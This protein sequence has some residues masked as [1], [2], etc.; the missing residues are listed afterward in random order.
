VAEHES[1]INQLH[2]DDTR[3]GSELAAS[4]QAKDDLQAEHTDVQS[5]SQG[6]T[7]TH[8]HAHTH[9]KQTNILAQ[10]FILN[11]FRTA[12]ILMACYKG[13]TLVRINAQ[14]L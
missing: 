13:H 8:T 7:H 14:K 4:Q 5:E 3:L 11:T 12:T 6:L 1:K 10:G 9:I 2:A